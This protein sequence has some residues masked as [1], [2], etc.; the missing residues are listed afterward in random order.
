[1]RWKNNWSIKRLFLLVIVVAT[2]P[3]I[4]YFW[5][6]LFGGDYSI[7]LPGG[8]YLSRVYAGAVLMVDPHKHIIISPNIDGYEVYGK[9]I[10][11]HVSTDKLPPDE[12]ANS[13]P[14]YF[15]VDTQKEII[16][17]GLSEQT[18]VDSLRQN[19]IME[20]PKLHKPSRF[21]AR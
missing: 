9:I 8:Y 10:T 17:Q 5:F 3:A 11:G 15:V 19:G 12:A 20:K 13:I 14:G 16:Q 4:V 21:Q 7:N 1:M 6:L 2:L 18:W